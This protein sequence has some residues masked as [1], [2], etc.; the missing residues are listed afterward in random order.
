MVTGIDP[1]DHIEARLKFTLLAR[2]GL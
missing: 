1:T 2:S